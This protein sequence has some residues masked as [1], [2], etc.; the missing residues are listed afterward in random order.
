MIRFL[1]DENFNINIVLG[2]RLR[3][4]SVDI[5]RVHEVGITRAED[6]A[7]LEWAAETRRVVLTHD[8]DDM[9]NYQG[10][11]RRTMLDRTAVSSDG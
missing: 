11:Y 6:P 8:A 5:V 2:V 7:V 10:V 3:N 4:S 1:V 9:P